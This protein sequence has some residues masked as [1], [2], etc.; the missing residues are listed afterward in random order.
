MRDCLLPQEHSARKGTEGQSSL[1][2]SPSKKWEEKKGKGAISTQKTKGLRRGAEPIYTEALCPRTSSLSQNH[3]KARAGRALKA[4]QV[5]PLP[6]VDTPHYS[7]LPRASSI[8]ALSTSRAGPP[9]LRSPLHWLKNCSLGFP[10]LGHPWEPLSG[11]FRSG[12]WD[13]N[14]VGFQRDGWF[15][16]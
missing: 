3:S 15:H 4:H 10:C 8:L 13:K 7:R 5:P 11:K 16:S 9:Q 6:W 1:L 12:D 14:Y 2:L